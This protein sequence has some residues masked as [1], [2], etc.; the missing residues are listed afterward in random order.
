MG[1]H[2]AC[3]QHGVD[4]RRFQSFSPTDLLSVLNLFIFPT[5]VLLLFYSSSEPP[6]TP[7]PLAFS[8]FST[9]S[10]FLDTPCPASI[11]TRP[12]LAF[13]SALLSDNGHAARLPRCTSCH[14]SRVTCR[15]TSPPSADVQRKQQQ[16]SISW[17]DKQLERRI[18]ESFDDHRATYGPSPISKRLELAI[19]N[20]LYRYHAHGY[21]HE[22]AEQVAST[23]FRL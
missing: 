6:S 7:S 20:Q 13:L 2:H 5:D 21:R 22:S 10:F 19:I 16:H 18:P 8:P 17:N 1:L 9:L 3:F 11:L 12:F 23:T 14:L 4:S 15:F